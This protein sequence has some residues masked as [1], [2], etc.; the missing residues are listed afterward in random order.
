MA[1]HKDRRFAEVAREKGILDETQID[2]LLSAEEVP[3]THP[4]DAADSASSL[5]Q[6]AVARGMLSLP[7]AHEIQRELLPPD[8]PRT[9]GRFEIV[10][11]VGTGGMGVVYKAWDP[12]LEVYVAIKTLMPQLA[13]NE[14]FIKRFEREAKLGAKLSTAHV[15]RVFDVGE[16]GPIHYIVME[17]VQGESLAQVLD[18]EG[19]LE[20]RRACRI[21]ADAARALEEARE[22]RIIHRDIKPA[23][24][25]LDRRGQVKV[26]DLGIAKQVVTRE[27]EEDTK[28]A[29]RVVG[30]TG[31]PAYMSPEQA[32]GRPLDFRTDIYSL[33]ATLFH[34]LCGRPPHEGDTPQEVMVS[35]AHD[36]PPDPRE[37]NPDLSE[38]A[39]GLLR[40][41][42]AK[43]PMMRYDSH[44]ELIA[45]LE[46]IADRRKRKRRYPATVAG[47]DGL[48]Q[49]RQPT[50]R[51]SRA[52]WLLAAMV[53]IVA[54]GGAGE[55]LGWWRPAAPRP[56][57]YEGT[58][59]EPEQMPAKPPARPPLT[60]RDVASIRS[61]AEQ[62][63]ERAKKLDGGQGF[64]L[65]LRQ[66]G[67]AH[68][69]AETF[70]KRNAYAEAKIGYQELASQCRALIELDGQRRAA[71]AAQKSAGSG[72]DAARQAGAEHAAPSL[73]QG[74]EKLMTAAMKAFS[75]RRFTKAEQ[76][77]LKAEQQYA[78]AR[79][80]H[81][82]AQTR[83]VP[84]WARV[85]ESQINAAA[86]AGV[87]PAMGVDLGRGVRIKLVYI[88][89]GAFLMGSPPRE[90]HRSEDEGPEHRVTFT[91]GIY[92]GIH[93]VT[94]AQWQAVMDTNP[95][96]FKG[97]R[98]PVEMVSWDDC[99]A[100][101]RKLNSRGS[102]N[103][104]LPAEAEWE[105]ACR[106]G[107]ST[108]FHFGATITTN[109]AN[110]DGNYAYARGPK[111]VHRKQTTVVGSFPY[112]AWGLYDMHGNVWEWCA[113]WYDSHW[114]RRSPATDPGGPAAGSARLLRG[115]SWYS[116]PRE[117][118]SA[119]RNGLGAEYRSWF[120]GFRVVRSLGPQ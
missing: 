83:P 68:R 50:R 59:T 73:W 87:A 100:F 20:Q 117:C 76:T 55:W 58:I 8:A 41:M 67:M 109:Q 91:R 119:N 34:L 40:R 10:E 94:Q 2:D 17:Y 85:S 13:A 70:L 99:Q 7:Q 86:A 71:L 16:D 89:P 104:R 107:T 46:S 63:W 57:R 37:A 69:T 80:L 52:S 66:A 1:T 48:P 35:V 32:L 75:A 18:R 60:P 23:N 98:R 62:V 92:M 101:I 51:A 15:V 44:P 26:A 114:Y 53:V 3:D 31:T 30:V 95:A 33:G 77:W 105:Y 22:H 12:R 38:R 96:C 79:R 106:A 88:P 61:E 27:D 90:R 74:A 72:A 11:A 6:V 102:G 56:A 120:C 115:G 19:R 29:S 112:N 24:I 93:E 43:N 84:A 49:A 81:A 108:P 42:M 36:P 82:E 14:D 9:L 103:F 45:D 116:Q 54:V 39:A 97:G 118:R 28:H 47:P 65:A 111:G 5:A 21:C 113:D 64:E 25:M 78:K 110:Y 4:P